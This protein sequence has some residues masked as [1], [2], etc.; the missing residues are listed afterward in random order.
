VAGSDSNLTPGAAP[1][2]S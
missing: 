1:E 2:F